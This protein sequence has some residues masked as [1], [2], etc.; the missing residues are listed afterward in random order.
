MLRGAEHWLG[1]KS[2]SL[3]KV[4]VFSGSMGS[5]EER[6]R[7]RAGEEK[8]EWE[9]SKLPA[10]WVQCGKTPPE[11]RVATL[12]GLFKSEIFISHGASES[13]GEL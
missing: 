11:G 5:G 12:C 2:T 8:K 10:R 1:L 3:W 13:S 6:N 7:V 4:K 9:R